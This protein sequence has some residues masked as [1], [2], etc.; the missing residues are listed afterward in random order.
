MDHHSNQTSILL[1]Y[2]VENKSEHRSEECIRSLFPSAVKCD[3]PILLQLSSLGD[4][5]E[6]FTNALS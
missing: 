6:D 1:L 2:S 3:A 4:G 5:S